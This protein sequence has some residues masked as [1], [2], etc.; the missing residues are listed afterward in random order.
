MANTDCLMERACGLSH[1]VYKGLL[2]GVGNCWATTQVSA[3]AYD[4]CILIPKLL[5][6]FQK[7]TLRSWEL[8]LRILAWD[9]CFS[10]ITFPASRSQAG[11]RE[12]RSSQLGLGDQVLRHSPHLRVLAQTR[13]IFTLAIFCFPTFHFAAILLL[14]SFS[15]TSYSASSNSLVPPTTPPHCNKKQTW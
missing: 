11:G 5:M 2:H 3:H 9:L 15:H 6:H 10:E 1:A 12:K 8:T 14:L 7:M 4:T 13:G